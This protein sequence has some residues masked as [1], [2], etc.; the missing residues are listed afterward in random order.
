MH[1]GLCEVRIHSKV[2]GVLVSR[3][4][5]ELKMAMW[6]FEPGAG[7]GEMARKLVWALY[8]GGVAAGMEERV[9]FLERL[10]VVCEALGLVVWSEM[11]AVL[12][13]VFF[14]RMDVRS[15]LELFG[16]KWS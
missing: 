9:W 6:G 4:K 13:S 2:I 1:T 3:L 11:R 16:E 10:G 5:A 7:G 12:E 15:E 14:G 8:F